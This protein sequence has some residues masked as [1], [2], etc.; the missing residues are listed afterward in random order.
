M[1][2]SEKRTPTKVGFIME[3]SPKLAYLAYRSTLTGRAMRK[4]GLKKLQ[5]NCYC[6]G[7]GRVWI[8]GERLRFRILGGQGGL[9]AKFS[10]AV[11]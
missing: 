6:T 9:G 8:L 1:V 3:P 10:L 2:T 11:N 7:V 4:L 5:L